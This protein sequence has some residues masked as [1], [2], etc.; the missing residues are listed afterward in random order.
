MKPTIAV[1]AFILTVWA[2]GMTYLRA[3]DAKSEAPKADAPENAGPRPGKYTIYS[4]GATNRPPL[5]LGYFV[6][7][8]D[9]TYKAFLPGDKAAGE[10]HYS[11]D[12]EKKAVVWKDGPYEKEWG[13]EFSIDREGKTHK[14]RLKK[15]TIATNSTDAEK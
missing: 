13:G 6:L 3:E 11:Y 15:T 2:N 1:I 4:Y 10:G 8:K 7:E 9:G 5:V 12:S 14:I